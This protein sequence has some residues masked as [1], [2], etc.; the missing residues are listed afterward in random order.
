[1]WHAPHGSWIITG[2]S[3]PEAPKPRAMK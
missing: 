3:I 1:M 2:I